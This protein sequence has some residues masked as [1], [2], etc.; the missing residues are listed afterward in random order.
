VRALKQLV[1]A[2]LK[3]GIS[4]QLA[5]LDSSRLD[6]ELAALAAGRG[7]IV[8]G[9]WLGEVG[10]EL[11]YWVPFLA[12]FAERFSVD[13]SRLL[14]LSRGGTRS[15]YEPFAEQYRDVLDYVTPEGFKAHHDARVREIGEQKQT[16][17]IAPEREL[18]RLMSADAGVSGAPLLHPS[19]MYRVMRPFWWGH[20]GPEW[21][22]RH[23]RYR[24]L[25]RPAR[26]DLPALPAAYVAVKFYFN[27]CFPASDANRALARDVVADLASRNAVVS[28]SAGID[29]DDHD[30][31]HVTAHA[32]IDLASA[33]PASRNLHVQ[34]AVVAH[35]RA[36]VGTYGGFAYL[37]PF[38]GVPCTAYYGD[39]N[40]FSRSHLT[41][42][43]TV[44]A[45]L[46]TPDLLEVKA[47]QR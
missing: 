5:R 29:L 9:P 22:Q 37:A 38:Y 2:T 3:H 31:C 34:S 19:L 15:W 16:R 41:M 20:L 4:A 35:A 40:G 24:A 8:A 12:W 10:F 46:G 28:L 18:L 47:I 43:Q 17:L 36:F 30:A 44:L 23:A 6:R 32:A 13:R 21:V 39:S 27:D 25:E 26:E 1:P 11:L 14:V 7:P 33:T 45:S 42:A